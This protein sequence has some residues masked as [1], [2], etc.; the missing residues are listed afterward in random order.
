MRLK[1]QV[2]NKKIEIELNT[3]GTEKMWTCLSLEDDPFPQKEKEKLIQEKFDDDFNKPEYNIWH[4]QDRHKDKFIDKEDEEPIYNKA[5]NK[6][7]FSGLT[8]TDEYAKCCGIV[9]KHLKPQAAEMAIA[10]ALNDVK[11]EDYAKSIGD[12]PNNVSHGYRRVLKKL[13]KL[14]KNVLFGDDS[15]Y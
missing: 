5:K 6:K 8:Q 13:N 12:T 14:G 3:E 10:I 4:K 2:E 7:A 11:A 9:R 1:V 15:G